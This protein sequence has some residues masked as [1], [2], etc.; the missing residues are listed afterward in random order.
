MHTNLLWVSSER[1]EK[2]FGSQGFLCSMIV[3]TLGI[4]WIL[5]KIMNVSIQNKNHTS[6][7][8]DGKRKLKSRYKTM[9]NSTIIQIQ[10][11]IHKSQNAVVLIFCFQ[12]NGIFVSLLFFS[13]NAQINDKHKRE[14]NYEKVTA[15][16]CVCK[17]ILHT[18]M[19]IGK[20]INMD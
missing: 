14:K 2:A 16:L 9:Y 5:I 17:R 1:E 15:I 4:F 13:W 11:Y 12:V 7:H 3:I 10:T 18:C 20:H 19:R 8:N 6:I